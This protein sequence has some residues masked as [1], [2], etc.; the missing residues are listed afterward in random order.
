[1]SLRCP[2]CMTDVSDHIGAFCPEC[3]ASRAGI[4]DAI[5]EDVYHADKGSLSVSGA[6][7]L[8]PPSCPAIFKYELDHGQ[9]QRDV[10]DYGK[11]AH[12]EALG[13]GAEVVVVDAD[14]WMTKAAKEA[15]VAAYA[16]DKVPLL[17]KDKAAVDAMGAALQAHPLASALLDPDNGKAE[18]SAFWD[19][20]TFGVLRRCRFDWLRE[21]KGGRLLLVDYKSCASAERNTFAKAAASYGYDM[22]A[23]WYTDLAYGLGLADDISFLFIAQEKTAPYLVN[24]IELD[25]PSIERGRKRNDKALG[26]YRDCT[27]ADV[28]PSYSDDVELVSLP[29]WAFYED[30][31]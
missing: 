29:R 31:A 20:P 21:A 30:A 13:V 3:G 18:V 5:P 28:W 16:E 4:H 17:A 25:A 9:Q 11:A 6:K 15:K 2:T 7:K 8:L 19:D 22:Q 26:I 1:M 23:A 27:E 14:N 12:K 10:F 24:V